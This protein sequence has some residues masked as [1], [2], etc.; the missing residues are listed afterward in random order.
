MKGEM[1]MK[2]TERGEQ[3]KPFEETRRYIAPEMTHTQYQAITTKKPE[4][5]TMKINAHRGET[6]SNGTKRAQ[7]RGN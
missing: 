6:I 7:I 2:E 1:E 3:G 4:E 5:R